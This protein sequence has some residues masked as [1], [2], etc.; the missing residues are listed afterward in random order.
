MENSALDYAQNIVD[1]VRE[2]LVVLDD[3]LR[4]ISANR[5][6]YRT[7]DVTPE[8][9]ENILLFDLGNRQ[10]N[11]PELRELLEEVLPE[12]TSIEDF[13][14]EH[15]FP[16]IG[17]KTMLLN[18][19]RIRSKTGAT[20][21]LLAI[22]DI[23]ERKVAEEALLRANE[24]LE[25]YAHTVSHDLKGPLAST[26]LV[27]TMLERIMKGKGL[28]AEGSEVSELLGILDNN[29]WKSA[30]LIDDLLALAEAGQT[31]DTLAAVDVSEVVRS[32]LEEKEELI[33]DRGV[34]VSVDDDLGVAVMDPTHASQVFSNLVGNAVKHN[35]S[36]NPEIRISRLVEARPGRLRYMVRDNGP[37]IP[38]GEMENI[39]LPFHKEAG[40]TGTGIG[41]S[42]VDKG[43]RLYGG[44]VR[45]YNDVGACFGFTLPIHSSQGP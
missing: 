24:E 17:Q 38:E 43:V 37:G 13:E 9:S 44:K 3:K 14:V 45:A 10:W 28:A 2:P 23:T 11:I 21:I 36:E 35:D 33:E 7:F 1:T 40:S 19:R 8:T 12:K 26:T 32:V 18:A 25:G 5:S 4:V 6:F 15:N 20:Q 39:F 16:A 42:I 31:P 29:V 30:A 41:L 22:E 27:A 34:Q